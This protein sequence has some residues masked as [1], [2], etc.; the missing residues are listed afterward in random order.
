M[1]VANFTPF[2]EREQVWLDHRPTLTSDEYAL[3]VSGAQPLRKAA[4][5]AHGA[6]RAARIVRA[7]D[8]LLLVHRLLALTPLPGIDPPRRLDVYDIDDALF[9]GS[10]AD[11]NR[12]FQWAK[13]E[14]RR[15]IACMRRARLVTAANEFLADQARPHATKVEVIPSCVDP[16]SQPL[17]QHAEAEILTIGWIGSHT[18]VDYLQPV[19]PVI[20]R[21]NEHGK[22]VVL[23]VV[24][25]DTGVRAEWIEHRSWSLARQPADLASFDIGIMPLPDTAWARGKAGYKLLQYFSAGVPA[26]ASPVGINSSLIGTERGLLATTAAQWEAALGELM[27]DTAQRRE[28]GAAGRAFVEHSYSYQRWTPE[29]ARLFTSLAG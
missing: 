5:L 28:R 17:R 29:L 22:R 15:S 13:Q 21:L 4:V 26:V 20:A 9:I 7:D 16:E 27:V 8:G 25:G 6:R 19:L 23:V 2:L 11:A 1:R 10:A 12:N 14:A 18:T 3:L 24:G